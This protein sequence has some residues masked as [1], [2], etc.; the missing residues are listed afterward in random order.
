M[1]RIL[2]LTTAR[3]C[4]H[5]PPVL[6]IKDHLRDTDGHAI[7]DG[8]DI[9]E[10]SV[11]MDPETPKKS[12][13]QPSLALAVAG[14]AAPSQQVR[15]YAGVEGYAMPERST[16]HASHKATSDCTVDFM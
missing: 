8:K 5:F 4:T 2:T 6:T 1:R 16:L 3:L 7:F 14:A 11:L 9:K 12:V 15:S 10:I 13:K